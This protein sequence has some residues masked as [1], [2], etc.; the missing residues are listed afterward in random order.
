M[1]FLLYSL[2]LFFAIPFAIVGFRSL[3]GFKKPKI[4]IDS[5]YFN[6][7]FILCN[8]HCI[9]S[10]LVQNKELKYFFTSE[11]VILKTNL[12]C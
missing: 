4:E 12:K 9:I 8:C 1:Y 7:I 11:V 6:F 2:I 3:M 10:L 5:F